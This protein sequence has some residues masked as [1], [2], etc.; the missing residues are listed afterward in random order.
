VGQS[1]SFGHWKHNIIQ[2]HPICQVSRIFRYFHFW[3]ISSIMSTYASFKFLRHDISQRTERN[4]SNHETA[5]EAQSTKLSEES[6]TLAYTFGRWTRVH[7]LDHSLNH[8]NSQLRNF[9]QCVS[10]FYEGTNTYTI[11]FQTATSVVLDFFLVISHRLIRLGFL[12]WR[13]FCKSS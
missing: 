10:L 11:V 13:I 4:T 6:R 5:T 2:S 7:E 8:S 9:L 3:N 12:R 1:R